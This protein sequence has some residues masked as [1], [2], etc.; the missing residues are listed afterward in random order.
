MDVAPRHDTIV[1]SVDT[2]PNGLVIVPS[3]L[4]A[5]STQQL[6]YCAM[7]PQIRHDSRRGRFLFLPNGQRSFI[8]LDNA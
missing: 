8:I 1:D 2:L 3:V 5:S 7:R 4:G 6:S